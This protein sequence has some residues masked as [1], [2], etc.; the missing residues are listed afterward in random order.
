[1][2]TNWLGVFESKASRSSSSMGRR[3]S[4]GRSCAKRTW[5]RSKKALETP[6][7]SQET[8][9]HSSLLRS[10]INLNS[11]KLKPLRSLCSRLVM[12]FHVVPFSN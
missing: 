7:N 10:E 12:L 2:P 4:P 3:R 9:F 8:R 5:L 1:M 6:L 11:F